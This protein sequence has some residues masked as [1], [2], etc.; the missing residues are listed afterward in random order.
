LRY[1]TGF[2]Y[3]IFVCIAAYGVVSRALTMYDE[4]EFTARSV[5]TAIFYQPYWFLYSIVDQEKSHLDDI[6]SNG[7]SSEAVAE[8]TVTHV[9]LAFHMLF[10]NILILNLLIAVFNFTINEVQDKN[11]YIWRY[12][13]Y[14]L[15]REYFEKPL[16]TFPPLSLLAY[17]GWIINAVIFQGTTFRVFSE[18]ND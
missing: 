3:I 11:E 16:F 9:L 6:I 5:L 17:I 13:K 18:Y 2:M 10:I 7:T 8:A 14:E 4:L 1:L 12:Q 15:I